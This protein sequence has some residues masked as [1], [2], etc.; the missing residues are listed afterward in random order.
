[1]KTIKQNFNPA[2]TMLTTPQILMKRMRKTLLILGAALVLSGVPVF[3]SHAADSSMKTLRGHV[4]MVV[5]QL[6]AKGRLASASTLNLAIGLPLRNEE[7]LTNLL[8]QI[9]DPSSPNYHHYL[10]PEEFTAQFGP[11]KEQYQEVVNFARVN[12]LTVTATHPNR[13]ILDVSGKSGDVEKAFHVT[14]RTYRH[15][16]EN[17]DF[18]A[19]DTEPTVPAIL[20][21][22]DISGLDNFRAPHP[23]LR[24]RPVNVSPNGSQNVAPSAGSGLGGSYIGDDFRRAYVPGT[25][26]N[27]SGQTI[28]L[29]QFDGYF[30]SD[31]AA[32]ESVAGRTNIPLQNVLLDGFSGN[33]GFN[34]DEVCLDI[35]MVISMAPALAKVI[36]YEGDPFNFHPN[37]V[38]NRIATDDSARQISCSWGWTGGPTSTT[39]Q[40]FQQM[41]LQGQSFFVSSGDSDAYQAGAVDNPFNFGTPADSPYVTSVGGTTLTMSGAGVSYAS[42]TVWN[43]GVEFGP[44]YDGIGS[45]GGTSSIYPIP[46]W[47]TNVNVVTS[48]GSATARNFPDVALTGDNVFVI[49]SGGSQ[50]IFGGTSCASPL[51]AGYTALMNQ[52]AT[53]NSHA[54]V[55][56]INPAI[57]A[58][59]NSPNYLNCFHDITT[60]NNE[61]SGSPTLFV[62]TNNYDLCTG[63]GTP[64]GTNL[65]NAL[66]SGGSGTNAITHLSAPLPPYGSTL[67]ALNGGNP[68]GTWELFVLDDA[69]LNSGIV[70]NGWMLTL[71]TASPVGFA[72][73]LA[74]GM[75]A[76]ASAVTVSN[77]FIYT[78]TI[79]NYGPS[80]S[81][82]VLV[83]DTLPLSVTVIS[84]NVDGGSL[85]RAGQVLNWNLGTLGTNSGSRLTVT[86]R[87]NLPGS[88]LNFAVAD[89]GTPD[90]YTGDNTASVTVTV[91][92]PEPP[93]LSGDFVSSNGM[94]QLTVSNPTNPPVSVIIEASTNLVDWLSIY[95]NT[96]VFTFTDSNA[97]DYPFRFY[98]AVIA[99]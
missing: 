66:T 40:I 8:Q 16:T 91:G 46:S 80:T 72:G 60:G 28:A 88:I 71:T 79:T 42:E 82:N 97:V 95:T 9:Y 23:R 7:A 13:M 36:V 62:A 87:P 2:T 45:S 18:F 59:A 4:P 98:R 44:N 94:F 52:Q 3:S 73:N 76:S 1:M 47:Q 54:P 50:G 77:D 69:A 6:K 58:I 38:L 37:D 65:I 92:V 20:P 33:P 78:L 35:E 22:Q 41:A 39:D 11:T 93:E 61:W 48:H 30:A 90:P 55:G 19:P 81:S 14:L 5:S 85:T 74:L 10:T 70:S 49:S 84:T 68:N 32:Y 75:T 83:S 86:V 57:Y 27:G 12:G 15:P 21:I 67:S 17:R 43:W 51:W 89:A 24:P 64:N 99:P 25:T 56:F 29:V 63:L 53:N 96:P 26:L 31:I 34:N